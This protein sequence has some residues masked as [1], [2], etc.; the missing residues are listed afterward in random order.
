MYFV[1]EGALYKGKF[2]LSNDQIGQIVTEIHNRAVY[3]HDKGIKFYMA[4]P[5]VKQEIYPE[6][7]PEL[8]QITREEYHGK[9]P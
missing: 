3:Y 8:L 1:S 5:P 4:I 2:T 7:L 9:D 6:Y